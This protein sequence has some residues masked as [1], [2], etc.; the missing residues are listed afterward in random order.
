MYKHNSFVKKLKKHFISFNDTLESYFNSLKYFKSNYK[1]IL[2]AKNNIVF[3]IIGIV[4]ILTPAY[5]T[6]PSFYDKIVVKKYIKNQI[7]NK[8][9]FEIRFN[10]KIVYGLLPKP[11]FS[12]KNLSILHNNKNI[13][14]VKNFKI[15]ISS[16]RLF[17]FNNMEL[18]NLIFEKTDFEIDKDDLNFFS[19]FLKTE[20]NE[21]KIIFKKSNIFFKNKEDE[22]LFISKIYNSEFFYDFNK[23]ANTYSSK[24]EIFNV[25]FK[26][27]IK[28]DKFNKKILSEFSSKK[29]RLNIENEIDYEDK[30]TKGLLDILFINKDT[31][32]SFLKKENSISFE[33]SGKKNFYNGI[34][35]FKPFYLS[36]NFNYE[37][38]SF[39]NFFSEDSIVFDLLRSELFNNLNL[40][41]SSVLNIKKIINFDELNNLLLNVEINQGSINLTN[42][43]I[44][45]KDDL[46]IT[47][48]D[49]LIDYGKNS[50]NLIGKIV[51]IVQDENDFYSS[52]QVKKNNRKDIKEIE[53]D[54][55]YDLIK[56]KIIFDNVKL[57]KKS[58]SKGDEFINKFNSKNMTLNKIL[59]KNFV[60]NFFDAY[61]G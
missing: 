49:G 29:L 42:S 8:Y 5:L 31:S 35:D 17:S 10:N 44:A 52:F 37:G 59:F 7:L 57:N 21:N 20:P 32:L 47:L 53:F 12:S 1:K 2:L 41:L 50:I 55:V 6:L 26:L 34:I 11:H 56:S 38:I 54:F 23:L 51:I 4:V 24:N 15:F 27:I 18:K 14:N 43:S 19:N 9:N 61:F 30:I 48:R 40:N 3:L 16:D 39:K 13:G 60:N 25:P 22:T 58:S 33:S 28:N 46:N 45:W 36:S